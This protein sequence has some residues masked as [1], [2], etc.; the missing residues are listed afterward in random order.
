M[1]DVQQKDG[2]EKN[3]RIVHSTQFIHKCY[4]ALGNKEVA[5]TVKTR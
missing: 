1:E 4:A 2:R 5:E 3:D